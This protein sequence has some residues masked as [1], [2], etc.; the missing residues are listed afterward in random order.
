MEISKDPATGMIGFGN[1]EVT[2][3]EKNALAFR[4]LRDPEP[5]PIPEGY[6]VRD[7]ILIK[8]GKPACAQGEF[9]FIKLLNVWPDCILLAARTKGMADGDIVLVSY[10]V[11]CDRFKKIRVVPEN[12]VFWGVPEEI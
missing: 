6:S 2:I 3:T 9:F 4:I 11:S 1:G 10:R 8:D 5:Y 7:G 12:I